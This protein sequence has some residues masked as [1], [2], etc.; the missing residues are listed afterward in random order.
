M[1]E[2]K[3][4]K[5]TQKILDIFGLNAVKIEFSDN[6]YDIYVEPR[7]DSHTEY[8]ETTYQQSKNTIPAISSRLFETLETRTTKRSQAPIR[9]V[10][11]EKFLIEKLF[12]R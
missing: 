11:I 10:I 8:N 6:T 3:N 12:P 5:S 2:T 7:S 1:K 4:G 9:P